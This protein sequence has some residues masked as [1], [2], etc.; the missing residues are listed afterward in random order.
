MRENYDLMRWGPTSA[1]S[2]PARFVLVCSTDGK[3]TLSGLAAEPKKKTLQAP[4][5]V[6][7]GHDLDFAGKLP[8][9][10]LTR[11]RSC[12]FL[13]PAQSPPEL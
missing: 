9:Q 5:T 13:V 12:S 7:I 2:S 3:A 1:N 8:K 11:P 4:V 6:L 10:C